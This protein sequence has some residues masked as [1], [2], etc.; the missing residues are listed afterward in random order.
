[1]DRKKDENED[2]FPEHCRTSCSNLWSSAKV[3]VYA[4]RIQTVHSIYSSLKDY[5]HSYTF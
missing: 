5:G 2:D 4:E 1:V 3:M